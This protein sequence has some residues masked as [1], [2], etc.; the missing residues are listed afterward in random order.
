MFTV[1]YRDRV[2]TWLVDRAQSDD[3]IVAAAEVGSRAVGGG[4]R[5]SDLDICLAAAADAPVAEVLEDW[6]GKVAGEFGAE[7]LFDLPFGAAVYRVFLFPGNLQVDLSFFPHGDFGSYGPEFRLL[8]G[9][10]PVMPRPQPPPARYRFGLAAHHLVRARLCVARGRLWQ[11][12]Y[13]LTEARYEA[14]AVACERAGVDTMHGRG[15]DR[16]PDRVL[17]AAASARARDVTPLELLRAL[18]GAVQLLAG[19]AD[20]FGEAGRRVAG[21]LAELGAADLDR[22]FRA[23]S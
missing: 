9:D 4:D 6:T 2:R 8:F 23:D 12:E 14:L 3:R 13:W 7:V 21:W 5:W 10:A 11:A 22:P 1:D 20:G 18:R 15:F 16:V 17:A 19:Q